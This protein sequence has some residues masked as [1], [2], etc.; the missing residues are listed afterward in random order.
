MLAFSKEFFYLIND[1]PGSGFS[2]AP[3]GSKQT[4]LVSANAL[5]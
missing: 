5:P 2:Q 3:A 4:P 1:A